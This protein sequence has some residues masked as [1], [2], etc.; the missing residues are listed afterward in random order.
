[1]TDEAEFSA[2]AEAPDHGAI[3]NFLRAPAEAVDLAGFA[4]RLQAQR[5]D[6][7]LAGMAGA[8]RDWALAGRL[9]GALGDVLRRSAS[10]QARAGEPCAWQPPCAYEAL[11]RKQGRMTA[12]VDFPSPWVFAVL[13]HRGDLILRLTLFGVACEWRV[14]AAEALAE[15][16][17]ERID[18]AAAVGGFAPRVEIV[19]RTLSALHAP[20]LAGADDFE[21][22]FLTPLSISS[23]DAMLDPRPAFTSFGL[24]LEGLARWQGLTFAALDWRA[25]AAAL[26]AADWE[27]LEGD[28]V[29]WRRGSRVQDTW[30]DMAG[31][32]G[33][34]RIAGP[35]ECQ[36]TLA[37]LIAM[38][39]VAHIGADIAFGCGRYALAGT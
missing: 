3:G 6:L 27:W 30:V 7:R 9:R 36:A 21:L 1:M 26:R 32:I 39:A 28:R 19:S 38:G 13:P 20:E 35:P 8:A 24:R 22:E 12:G 14:A 33:R 15:I 5:I 18:W 31:A 17:V 10:P 25:V 29:A 11:F 37:P 23:G 2:G 16:A 4:A 34:L